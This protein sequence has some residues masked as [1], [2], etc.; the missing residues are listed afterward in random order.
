MEPIFRKKWRN[1]ESS[2]CQ[3]D[4][5]IDVVINLSLKSSLPISLESGSSKSIPHLNKN[6]DA[7]TKKN[8]PKKGPSW[9]ISRTQDKYF[10]VT[11]PNWIIL[12]KALFIINHI[13]IFQSSISKNFIRLHWFVDLLHNLFVIAFLVIE[14]HLSKMEILVHLLHFGHT[15]SVLNWI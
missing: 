14:V 13:K 5:Y 1:F 12:F 7:S 3:R 11:R 10:V 15:I 8:C 2:T 4:I 6:T 9:V